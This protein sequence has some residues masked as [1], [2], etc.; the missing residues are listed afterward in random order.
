[1]KRFRAF[2]PENRWR[3][4]ARDVITPKRKIDTTCN[5]SQTAQPISLTLF[6]IGCIHAQKHPSIVELSIAKIN[7]TQRISAPVL[8]EVTEDRGAKK[9]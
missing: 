5:S 1:M 2:L 7:P 8:I 6:A 3:C 4:N 9:G